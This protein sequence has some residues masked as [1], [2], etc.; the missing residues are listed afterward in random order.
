MAAAFLDINDCNL[1]LW[2]GDRQ[3]QS[4]GYALL[5]GRDYRFGQEARG[6]ARLQPRKVNTRYWWQLSTE[7]LQPALG[8][9]RHTAD[10]V[11]AHL[12]QLHRQAGEPEELQLAVS[13]GMS[14]EQLSLLLGI[15]Q[16]CPFDAVS[17]V[18]RSALLAS[19]YGGGGRLFH[20]EIQ[21]H[22]ALVCEL[23][24][25]GRDVA[26]QRTI[27]LPGCGLLQMQ[28][29]LVETLA[30]NFIQQTRFDPRRK[31]VTEQQLYDALP[32][33]L[34]ALTQAA[35]TNLEINGYRARVS[36]DDLGNAS[37]RLHD[38]AAQAIGGLEARDRIIAEPLAALLPGI[39][40]RFEQLDIC[41]EDA[42]WR[43]AREH[44]ESLMSRGQALSFVSVLPCLP[45]G[46]AAP[47]EPAVI[48]PPAP[49]TEPTHL[50]NGFSASPLD[51][52]G[53]TVEQG[54]ELVHSDDGWQLRADRDVSVNNASYASGQMLQ[55]GDVLRTDSGTEVTLIEVRPNGG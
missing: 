26:S 25:I 6:A 30:S 16:Q 12:L 46:S 48:D 11:H 54:L 35:E 36:R 15:A 50:L 52:A 51:R 44:G 7:A 43:A 38:A 13:A 10:L 39:G 22:Q 42:T 40:K 27:P 21:L 47:I 49:V 31:A 18:N 14:R 32:G 29:Q 5:E 34:Q 45:S 41:A 4:P 20:L 2:H 24:P 17:L 3:V 28:E 53:T 37:A 33:A 23:A 8:P 19:L 55:A 9:A 1:R